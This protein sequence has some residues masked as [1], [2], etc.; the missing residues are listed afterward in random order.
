MNTDVGHFFLC[1]YFL[2]CFFFLCFFL[3]NSHSRF[4]SPPGP[5]SDCSTSHI[6]SLTHC[7]HEDVPTT[8]R[9]LNSL[10]PPV[11]WGLGA[12]SLIEPRLSIPLLYMCWGLISAGVCYL[13]GGPVSERSGGSRLID[14]AGP[15]TGSPSSSASSSFSLIQLQELII[16]WVQI[17]TS[18]S[19]SYLLGISE[20]IL[21]SPFFCEPSIS[22]VIVSGLGASPWAG[23]HFGHV[24]RPCFPQAP[25][26]FHPWSSF[27]Q[28]K[29]WV[30]VLTVGW[31]PPPSLNALSWC[32][33]NICLT[34]RR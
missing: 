22:S 29:I 31:Q 17:S 18:D 10:G 2:F 14:T 12:S 15:P 24:T 11:S 32:L 8:T 5:L 1:I 25:L 6:S 7:L 4:Y 20:Y 26:H 33:T 19:F 23:S 9:P 30:R 16:G 27:R 3:F 28:E 21:I 34:G 13:V